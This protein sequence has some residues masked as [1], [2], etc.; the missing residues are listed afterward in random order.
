MLSSLHLMAKFK[1]ECVKQAIDENSNMDIVEQ[2]LAHEPVKELV[3]RK[4]L[5]FKSYQIDPKEIKCHFQS[6]GKHETMFLTI[7]FCLYKSQ[8]S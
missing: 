6:W 1:V 5:I 4:L 3:I 2:M 8:S 7:G